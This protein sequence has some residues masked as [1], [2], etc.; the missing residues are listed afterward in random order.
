[1]K[2]KRI[3]LEA[4]R[5]KLVKELINLDPWIQGTIVQT[6]RMCGSKGCACSDGIHIQGG[7]PG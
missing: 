7:E 6:K 4:R 2:T 1:M 5:K 3:K